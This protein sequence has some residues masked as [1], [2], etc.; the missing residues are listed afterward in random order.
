MQT[1]LS[2]LAGYV[3]QLHF[4]FVEGIYSCPYT[5]MGWGA[6]GGCSLWFGVHA[7]DITA[8]FDLPHCLRNPPSPLPSSIST[9]PPPP[10][11]EI[12]G[13]REARVVPYHPTTLQYYIQVLDIGRGC[14]S[15]NMPGSATSP[16]CMPSWNSRYSECTIIL[17][18][19]SNV[20]WFWC[21]SI[22][23]AIY[24]TPEQM[25]NEHW[26]QGFRG[27]FKLCLKMEFFQWK[28][29]FLKSQ[30]RWWSKVELVSHKG[31]AL[32]LFSFYFCR[33][34]GN[35]YDVSLCRGRRA[36]V[37]TD[38][39]LHEDSLLYHSQSR[40]Q[41][42][43]SMQGRLQYPVPFI[44]QRWASD[45]KDG[46]PIYSQQWRS[47][48]TLLL[49]NYSDKTENLWVLT[50]FLKKIL[51]FRCRDSQEFDA[52]FV[53]NPSNG[54]RAP[55]VFTGRRASPQSLTPF[56]LLGGENHLKDSPPSSLQLLLSAT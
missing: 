25:K 34:E 20:W 10:Q 2:P 46:R 31:V 16:I 48:P 45:I 27:N 23:N 28:Q 41:W 5:L 26:N 43:L 6:P 33:E 38:T 21:T 24:F 7:S 50:F 56:C 39:S 17:E 32:F 49:L 13:V 47:P 3:T 54:G 18:P 51:Q 14:W 19:I 42:G 44:R 40:G 15:L 35:L 37:Q 52:Y 4:Q 30:V 36:S 55:N 9:P 11:A 1:K 8:A 22:G 53:W 12:S 29:L